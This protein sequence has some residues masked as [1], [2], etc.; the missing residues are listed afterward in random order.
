MKESIEHTVVIPIMNCSSALAGLASVFTKYDVTEPYHPL[1]L[2]ILFTDSN[3]AISWNLNPLMMYDDDEND[4]NYDVL[5][6]INT[7]RRV[8]HALMDGAAFMEEYLPEAVENAKRLS[9]E[10][11]A[12]REAETVAVSRPK[13]DDN[14]GFVRLEDV[15]S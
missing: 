10:S 11:K 5:P 12:E 2:S 1:R 3:K 14:S 6:H 4:E 8:A 13:P 15:P 9:A 7:I